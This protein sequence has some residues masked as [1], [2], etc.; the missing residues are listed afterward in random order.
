MFSIGHIIALI[1]FLDFRM[2]HAGRLQKNSVNVNY[3][4]RG[5]DN[6]AAGAAANNLASRCY[7]QMTDLSP[8]EQIF[9]C[10]NVCN[11]R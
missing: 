2:T 11:L 4:N 8:P 7:T 10:L 1:N 6:G 9:L 3:I 5:V